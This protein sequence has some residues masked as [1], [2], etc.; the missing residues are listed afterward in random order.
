MTQRHVGD[1]KGPGGWCNTATQ[2]PYLVTPLHQ[3]A[4]FQDLTDS[5]V[6]TVVLC[7]V[8]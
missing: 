7:S 6:A 5:D 4:A 1:W 3:S 8:Q 2:R